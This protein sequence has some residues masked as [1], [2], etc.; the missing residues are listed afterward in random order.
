M[1]SPDNR[2]VSVAYP[3]PTIDGGTAPVT[4]SC[5]PETASA[6]AVGTSTVT[7]TVTD[8]QTRAASCSFPV[9]VNPAL[10]LNATAI[11]AFGDSIT[12]GTTPTTLSGMTLTGIGC[13]TG[14]AVAYPAVMNDLLKTLYPTQSVAATNCGWAGEEATQGVVRLPT[15]LS[16][17]TYDVVLLMEG[18]NDLSA[19]SG[20]S[21]SAA[22]NTIANAIVSM[23]RT[24]RSGRTVFV[25]TLTPQ[26]PGGKGPRPEWVDPVN[27][28]LRSVVPSEGAV[29][30]DTWQALGGSPDPYIS[31]D[32]LHPTSAGYQRIA[33]AFLSAIRGALETRSQP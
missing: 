10:R 4:T 11:L 33:D 17:G 20:G 19:L 13:H 29:L 31:S 30:V 12:E 24:A 27:A 8:A 22:V 3:K 23:I 7:C 25:G 21:Q 18:A 6:F 9:T 5:T 14:S 26:R 15:G 2:P 16:T 32:G 1:L 28:R